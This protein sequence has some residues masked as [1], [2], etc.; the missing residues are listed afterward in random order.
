MPLPTLDPLGIPD[1]ALD[2]E[3]FRF[4]IHTHG[5]RV[6]WYRSIPCPCRN[7]QNGDYTRECELQCNG[8]YFYD[9]EPT[10]DGTKVY[11]D[12]AKKT[13]DDSQL[14]YV[15]QGDIMAYSM[16][17]EVPFERLDK[18]VVM[19]WELEIRETCNRGT[20]AYDYLTQPWGFAI[21]LAGYIANGAFVRLPKT[22]YSLDCTDKGKTKFTW[23]ASAPAAGQNYTIIYRYRPTVWVN[24]SSFMPSRMSFMQPPAPT[25]NGRYGLPVRGLMALKHPEEL[26]PA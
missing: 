14:G 17:D 2:P 26:G 24:G 12:R 15:T 7:P 11:F 21:D 25:A 8:G 6:K 20:G 22:A 4:L 18:L 3:A 5:A 10:P 16:P 9:L 19:D 1:R 13:V 23:L